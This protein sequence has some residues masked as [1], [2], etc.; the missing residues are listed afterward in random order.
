[1]NLRQVKYLLYALAAVC[2]L[3]TV[4][5]VVTESTVF[6]WLLLAFAAAVVVVNIRLWRCPSCGGHLDRG[7]PKYCP[8]CGEYLGDLQ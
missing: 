7:V 6:L 4:L 2:A 5:F 8:H 1:M 3:M